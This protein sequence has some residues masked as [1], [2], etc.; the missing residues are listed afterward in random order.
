MH[1]GSVMTV[2][3]RKTV[4]VLVGLMALLV[5]GFSLPVVAME[6]ENV[7]RT[8]SN[9][10]TILL[11]DVLTLSF[12][13]DWEPYTDNSDDFYKTVYSGADPEGRTLYFCEAVIEREEYQF[14]YGDAEK[15][16][17]EF[18]EAYQPVNIKGF[19]VLAGANDDPFDIVVFC[20]FNNAFT[21]SFGF[22]SPDKGITKSEKLMRD[23]KSILH[24]MTVR[25]G[26]AINTYRPQVFTMGI[27]EQDND[28]RNGPEPIEWIPLAR[29]NGQTLVISRYALDGRQFHEVDENTS[30][31]KCSLRKWLNH[32]FL[33]SAFTE[34]ERQNIVLS[35]VP[36]HTHPNFGTYAGNPTEDKL[37][38]LSMEEVYDYFDSD[39]SRMCAGTEYCY[40]QGAEEW[41]SGTCW[42]WLRS[43]GIGEN[44]RATVHHYGSVHG[45]GNYAV[46]N[47]YGVRPAMWIYD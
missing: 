4:L 47:I 37:F 21:V 44:I 32:E 24:S 2:K 14:T 10:N 35:D 40:V 12:P 31:E 43:P 36:A 28:L 39:D 29:K 46:T 26:E 38:L 3:N 5:A 41:E 11:G 17:D 22:C 23:I 13:S 8:E 20:N 1:E 19:D 30:W 25:D 7:E 34:E 18:D 15:I 45:M 6:G 9:D 42:W 27:F 33:M 16:L